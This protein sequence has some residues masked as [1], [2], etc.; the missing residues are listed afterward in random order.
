VLKFIDDEDAVVDPWLA[1]QLAVP[2]A[3]SGGGGRLQT[4]E[5]TSHLETVADVLRR[6][7]VAAVVWGRRGGPGGLAVG[8]DAVERAAG[9]DPIER[10]RTAP[11]R[12]G[13]I[14]PRPDRP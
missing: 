14:D 5:V 2:F 7:G 13:A 1:D 6:F 8:P 3:I 4:S 12:A 10:V 11:D 9:S